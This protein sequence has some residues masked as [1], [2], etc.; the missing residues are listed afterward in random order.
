MVKPEQRD[1]RSRAE[2][3]YQTLFEAIQSGDLK[4]G[5]RIREVDLA[6]QFGISRTPIRDAILKLESEGLLIHEARKGAVIKSLSHREIIELYAMREVLEGTAARYAAQHASAEEIDELDELNQLMRHH[7]QEPASVVSIN[8][9]FHSLLYNCANNRY[10]IAALRS[11]SNAMVLLGKTTLA[12]ESR[13]EAAFEE[14]QAIVSALRARDADSAEQ[15]ARHHIVRAKAERL[16]LLR[17][18]P[19]GDTDL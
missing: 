2:I 16:K 15:A 3:A 1:E 5:T 8:R 14:H 19:A 10:L 12:D 18:H 4:P 6:E 7:K 9:Q 17:I 13:T 11:L